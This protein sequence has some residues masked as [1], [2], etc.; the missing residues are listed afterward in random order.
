MLEEVEGRVAEEFVAGTS[1][2]LLLSVEDENLRI[3]L[4]DVTKRGPDSTCETQML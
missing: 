1:V 2:E 4:I 3:W